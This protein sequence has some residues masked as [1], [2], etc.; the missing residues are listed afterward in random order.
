VAQAALDLD[1]MGPGPLLRQREIEENLWRAIR[2]G[3]D[4][5][6]IDFERRHTVPTRAVAEELLEWC[7]PARERLRVEVEIPDENG[8]QRARR[9][10]AEGSPIEEIFR[11]AVEETRRTYA[12]AQ[13]SVPDD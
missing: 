5:E 3:L 7:A 6:M 10:F 13:V 4:G 9:R 1:E 11:G 8:A 12:P 2:H